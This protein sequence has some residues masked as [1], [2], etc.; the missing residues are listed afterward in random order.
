MADTDEERIYLSLVRAMSTGIQLPAHIT[1]LRPSIEYI[2]S[3]G[4]LT[5][6]PSAATFVIALGPD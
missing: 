2:R 1:T 6:C 3:Y 4:I 5:V